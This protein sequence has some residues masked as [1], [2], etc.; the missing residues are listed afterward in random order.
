MVRKRHAS[1]LIP[2]IP[3]DVDLGF[4]LL[5][6]LVATIAM[7]IFL[8]L[9]MPTLLH[10]PGYIADLVQN[11]F[12][13][14]LF[15]G[16]LVHL[17]LGALIFPV[18]FI[19]FLYHRF[20]GRP[21]LRGTLWGG[22]LWLVAELVAIPLA[23]GGVFHTQAGGLGTAVGFLVGHLLYGAV[24]GGVAGSSVP[25]PEEMPDASSR[26]ADREA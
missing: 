13:V 23:G 15:L 2:A 22:I 9:V 4:T 17:L 5:G 11:V 10:E 1:S 8:Y 24:L 14:N 25:S 7:T 20:P 21:W 6:G 26:P 12:D 3:K 16:V 19:A 18:F